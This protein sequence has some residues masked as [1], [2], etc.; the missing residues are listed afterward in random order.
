MALLGPSGAGKS[1]I[2]ALLLRFYVPSQGMRLI[3]Y[4]DITKDN[5]RNL[6][7]KVVPIAHL[8]QAKVEINA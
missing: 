7:S 1:S 2:V 5:L 4:Q 6:N 8:K 3:D